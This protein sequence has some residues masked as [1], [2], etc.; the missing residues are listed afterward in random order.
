MNKV[1]SCCKATYTIKE[2]NKYRGYNICDT[3]NAIC[4]LKDTPAHT[5]GWEKRFHVLWDTQVCIALQR[6]REMIKNFIKSELERRD[7]ELI[8]IIENNNILVSCDN[9]NE[10]GINGDI[11]YYIKPNVI[12]LIK[13]K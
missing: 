1:T 13:N 7:K 12:N 6:E 9:C 4:S 10:Q 2:L 8:E 11:G 3:C 5:E